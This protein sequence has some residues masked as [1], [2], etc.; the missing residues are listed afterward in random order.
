[1]ASI[2]RGNPIH[3]SAYEPLPE[4]PA[5]RPWLSV[6]IEPAS[7]LSALKWGALIG[8]AYYIVS[9]IVIVIE[10]ALLQGNANP[11][12]NLAFAVPLCVG[13][14]AII[15]ALYSAGYLAGGERL[16]VAPGVLSALVMIIVASLLGKIY[17]PGVAQTSTVKQPASSPVAQIAG[18][19]VYL[20]IVIGIGY[21]GGFY[22]VKN[23]L[24]AR[25]KSG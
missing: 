6:L 7:L 13:V 12:A 15:F 23:K 17:T 4:N 8:V 21:L 9:L 22:G 16:H 10:N 25:A 24:K 5:R 19:I 14:F 18:F 2:V 20:A 1:V 11:A 3:M